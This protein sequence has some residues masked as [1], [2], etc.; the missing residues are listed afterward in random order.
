MLY[1]NLL[2]DMSGDRQRLC[3]AVRWT[4]GAGMLRSRAEAIRAGRRP[5]EIWA[6]IVATSSHACALCMHSDRR[7]DVRVALLRLRDTRARAV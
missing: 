1:F 3:A 6:K 4:Q 5:P 7:A 2:T